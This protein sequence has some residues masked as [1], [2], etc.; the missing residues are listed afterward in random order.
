MPEDCAAASEVLQP[1]L[2]Q[3]HEEREDHMVPPSLC[4]MTLRGWTSA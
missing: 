4:L 2:A 3:I 1:I